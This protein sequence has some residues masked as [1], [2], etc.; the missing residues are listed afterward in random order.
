M[1][2]IDAQHHHIGQDTALDRVDQAFERLQSAW[3]TVLARRVANGITQF[4]AADMNELDTAEAEWLA[5]R[6]EVS[7]N[8]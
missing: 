5:V 4:D 2:T 6:A 8:C 3:R 1:V 7:I